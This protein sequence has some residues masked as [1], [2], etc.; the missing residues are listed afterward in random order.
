MQE[1]VLSHRLLIFTG[2]PVFFKC[3]Q[4]CWSEDTI[5]DD[6]PEETSEPLLVRSAAIDIPLIGDLD[7]DPIPFFT[8]TSIVLT[9][10][11]RVLT[12]ESDTLDASAGILAVMSSRLKC[13][14]LAGLP[15]G[16]FDLAILFF[17]PWID[18]KTGV[19]REGFPSWSWAG[20]RTCSIMMKA[21]RPPPAAEINHWLRTQTYI[22][23]HKRDPYTGE[24]GLVWDEHEGL[25][26]DAVAYSTLARGSTIPYGRTESTRSIGLNT[27]PLST[28]DGGKI[29][30]EYPLLQFWAYT[31]E[32]TVLEHPDAQAYSSYQR[33]DRIRGPNGELCG[34]I[35]PNDPQLLDAMAGRYECVLLSKADGHAN[36]F[37]DGYFWESLGKP[38]WW[39][40]LIAWDG[41]VAER[42]GL[43]FIYEDCL[44]YMN[45]RRWKE[46]VLA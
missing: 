22:V 37:N 35:R 6:F 8:Y 41:P 27:A 31:V 9:Y 34:G 45:P 23:W 2:G 19:R 18:N 10:S 25:S 39:V 26:E 17:D 32:F 1:H 3:H 12:K 16:A 29:P 28:V 20:W 13:D 15:T 24:L 21:A 5:Y 30:R 44:E 11:S 36:E 40:M 33:T 4:N 14:M 7:S 43:G 38:I 46:I 42:R